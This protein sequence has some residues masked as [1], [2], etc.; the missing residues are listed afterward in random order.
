LL[1]QAKVKIGNW[2]FTSLTA[3]LFR[4]LLEKSSKSREKRDENLLRKTSIYAKT[5]LL[6]HFRMILIAL[7][8]QQSSFFQGIYYQLS[9]A[10]HTK[11]T[12]FYI[13]MGEDKVERKSGGRNRKL[14]V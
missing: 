11:L 13:M 8:F 12:L 6:K 3:I 10:E 1:L 9:Q 7:P 5:A 14:H 2:I 4:N